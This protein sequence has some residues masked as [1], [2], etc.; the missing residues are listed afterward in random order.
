MKTLIITLFIAV[1]A[2]TVNAQ[3]VQP[4]PQEKPALVLIQAELLKKTLQDSFTLIA[5]S[6]V[7]YKDA[8]PV[9]TAIQQLFPQV[10]VFKPD[11]AKTPPTKEGKKKGN[12]ATTNK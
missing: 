5:N 8:A 7:P 11:T 12:N 10:N 6:N 4:Q 2:L 9:L 3:V 1:A